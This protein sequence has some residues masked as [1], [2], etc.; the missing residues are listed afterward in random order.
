MLEIYIGKLII[1]SL[2]NYP[3]EKDASIN[4]SS[5]LWTY[6]IK[7]KEKNNEFHIKLFIY[8][9]RLWLYKFSKLIKLVYIYMFWIVNCFELQW[10]I[11]AG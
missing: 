2:R 5:L 10:F 11:L 8:N 7:F 1:F 9:A 3:N 4:F 6:I